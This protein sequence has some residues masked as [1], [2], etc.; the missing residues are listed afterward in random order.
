MSVGGD[1]R[2]FPVQVGVFEVNEIADGL[3]LYQR[4]PERVHYLNRIASVVY[5]LCTGENSVQQIAVL[6]GDAF[7]LP[8]PPL[9]EVRDCL[10]TL[11]GEDVVR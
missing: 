6:I 4:A 1:I 10:A 11:R 3:V 8:Q 7:G 5:E 2:D 9:A